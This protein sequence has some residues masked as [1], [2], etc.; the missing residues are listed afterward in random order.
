MMPQF[1]LEFPWW[2]K[3]IFLCILLVYLSFCLSGIYYLI[4]KRFTSFELILS[5]GIALVSIIG[6]FEVIE[7]FFIPIDLAVALFTDKI[8]K[9]FNIFIP[10]YIRVLAF[11]PA[12]FLIIFCF[13]NFFSRLIT[14]F[15]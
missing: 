3:A 15:Q 7:L 11:F 8:A 6:I 2:M 1:N 13:I 12:R 5:F 4:C 9:N 14:R 10:V